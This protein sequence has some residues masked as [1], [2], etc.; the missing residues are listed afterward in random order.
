MLL[1]I[2][3]QNVFIDHN[4][5]IYGFQGHPEVSPPDG[6][7]IIDNFLSMCAIAGS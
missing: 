3:N 6:L 4:K 5:P 1:V 2:N 7:V